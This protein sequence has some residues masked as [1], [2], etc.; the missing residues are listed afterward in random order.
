[1]VVVVVVCSL[2]ELSLH[3]EL[4]KVAS[5][6]TLLSLIINCDEVENLIRQPVSNLPELHAEHSHKLVWK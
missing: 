5:T 4:E 1:M 6:A 2:A 3:Y